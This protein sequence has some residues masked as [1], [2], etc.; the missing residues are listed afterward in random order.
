M[1]RFPLLSTLAAAG[2]M[3]A[4]TLPAQ[5]QTTVL[6]HSNWFPEGQVMRVNV[7]EPWKAEV[8]R[9]TEGR[10]KIETL[11]KVVGS[12]QGQYD[13]ARDG[14]ADLVVFSNGYTPGRFDI[15]EVGELPFN[16][17]RAEI[18]GPALHRFY[19][20][21]V[22]QY[23]EYRGVVPLSVFVVAAPELF[24]NQRKIETLD[25]FKGLKIRSNSKGTTDL[26]NLLGAVPVSRP[27]TETYE[28]MS[29]GVLDGTVM[30]P[31]SVPAFN[32]VEASRFAT[33]V[34]GAITNSILT[35]AIN[36]RKWKSLSQKDRDAIMAI[37]GET[38]A[39]QI[40]EAYIEGNEAAWKA[41]RDAGQSVEVA[42][43]E[44]LAQMKTALAPLEDA[45]AE[46]ARKRGV[47]DPQA[48]LQALRDE[49]K[50]VENGQ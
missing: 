24:N 16:G 19:T 49:V 28:L 5:A 13:V 22:A 48:L 35:L 43:P 32:L 26:L 2:L 6:R 27:A 10:V 4:V 41:L 20:E 50:A 44:L 14:Q 45:W 1:F 23:G 46:R 39:R 25:D 40:G 36:E 8:E 15:L 12:V 9:V 21:H 34:P 7:I 3:A 30:P 29:S 47:K 33:I 38:F 18:F 31:E 37:S 17:D 42:N 11:P